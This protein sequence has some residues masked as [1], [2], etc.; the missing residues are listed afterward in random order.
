MT[1][2]KEMVGGDDGTEM[3]VRSMVKA[4]G[5]GRVDRGGGTII[6]NRGR[7][8]L[9]EPLVALSEDTAGS[10]SQHTNLTDPTSKRETPPP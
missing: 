5:G 6:A 4:N 1:G 7:S 2:Q 8:E 10:K 9:S 3:A